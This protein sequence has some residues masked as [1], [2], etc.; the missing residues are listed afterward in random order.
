MDTHRQV[1][2]A[3]G[4]ESIGASAREPRDRGK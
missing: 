2:R 4:L 1:G 3:G